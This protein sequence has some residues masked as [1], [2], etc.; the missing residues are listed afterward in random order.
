MQQKKNA[1]MD[2]NVTSWPRKT[3][4]GVKRRKIPGRKDHLP[5]IK[6]P[7]IKTVITT[8]YALNTAEIALGRVISYEA[9]YNLS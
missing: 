8:V 6:Y 1:D 5:F 3:N 2:S 4:R 7:A 9:A